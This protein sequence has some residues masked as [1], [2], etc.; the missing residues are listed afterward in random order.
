MKNMKKC[1]REFEIVEILSILVEI[2][3]SPGWEYTP[4]QV[5]GFSGRS[6]KLNYL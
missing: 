5:F 3:D 4:K 6:R 1:G 2:S